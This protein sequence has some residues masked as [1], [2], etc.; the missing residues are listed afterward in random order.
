MELNNSERANG[1]L[2]DRCRMHI[3]EKDM[4]NA[5]YIETRIGGTLSERASNRD[6][7]ILQR[8]HEGGNAHRLH[9]HGLCNEA[10]GTPLREP[11]ML[12]FV[13]SSE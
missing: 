12:A 4:I 6:S 5:D 11:D 8:R 1:R 13:M 3:M 7:C 9:N 10:G 2:S